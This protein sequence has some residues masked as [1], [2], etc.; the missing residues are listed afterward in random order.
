MAGLFVALILPF[1]TILCF[2]LYFGPLNNVA[3]IPANWANL[4]LLIGIVLLAEKRSLGSIGLRPL[5]WW[6]LPLGVLAGFV[7]SL[8]FPLLFMLMVKLGIRPNE[9]A[10][11]RVASLPFTFRLIIVVTAAVVEE[12]LFR[13][14]PIERMTLILGNKWLA[15]FITVIV[16][17][18]AHAP[19]WGAAQMIP[20]FVA[21]VFMTLLYLWKRDLALNIIA[22]FILDGI[23]FLL[24]PMLAR[25]GG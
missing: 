15:G 16:F 7:I 3:R 1:L 6:T 13:A 24:V 22:H 8:V 9:A 23:G 17:T 20:V 12:T 19:F 2:R 21:S 10:F 25:H 14:Y 4:L 5:R 11:E 18:V